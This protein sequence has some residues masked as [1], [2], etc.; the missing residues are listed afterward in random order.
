METKHGVIL[1]NFVEGEHLPFSNTSSDILLRVLPHQSDLYTRMENKKK[2][3]RV[4]QR[5]ND[6]GCVCIENNLKTLESLDALLS[7]AAKEGESLVWL[8]PTLVPTECLSSIFCKWL[9]NTKPTDN[10][11]LGVII[12]QSD[13]AASSKNSFSIWVSSPTGPL[14]KEPEEIKLPVWYPS[15]GREPGFLERITS[16]A[17]PF[18][19]FPIIEFPQI[20]DYDNE[21]EI[22][23][24]HSLLDSYRTRTRNLI[25]LNNRSP[26]EALRTLFASFEAVSV[27]GKMPRSLLV[28]PGGTS[29]SYLVTLLAAVFSDAIFITPENETPFP[30]CKDIWG[31]AIFKKCE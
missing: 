23:A 4:G 17:K 18:D 22:A 26:E 8:D 7:R 27:D 29:L 6:A 28:T 30:R 2:V 31:F 15:L 14:K 13:S 12:T 5:E 19:I 24:H 21:K 9:K 10:I 11:G 16:T 3:P 25:Y 20:I 1:V